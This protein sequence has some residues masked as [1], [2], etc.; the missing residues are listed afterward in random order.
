MKIVHE[1]DLPKQKNHTSGRNK[2]F[3]VKN[4]LNV[5]LGREVFASGKLMPIGQL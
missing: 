5:W 3:N 4:E 2:L 1:E